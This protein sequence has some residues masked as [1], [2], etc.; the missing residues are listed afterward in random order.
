ME[1]LEDIM[2]FKCLGQDLT[3]TPTKIIIKTTRKCIEFQI[4]KI[5]SIVTKKAGLFMPGSIEFVCGSTEEIIYFDRYEKSQIHLIKD[6]IELYQTGKYDK[7]DVK[8]IISQQ[9][10]H[11]EA[12]QKVKKRDWKIAGVLFTIGMTYFGYIYFSYEP[13]S[14]YYPPGY[15]DSYDYNFDGKI[16]G[17]DVEEFVKWKEQNRKE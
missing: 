1:L 10:K 17:A 14:T 16:D 13:T 12:G 2:T 6:L 4:D 8:T 15:N 7:N 11:I 9:Q 5:S 3:I